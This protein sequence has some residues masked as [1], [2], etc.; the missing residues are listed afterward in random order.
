MLAQSSRRRANALL[1]ALCL[2]TVLPA[3][4]STVGPSG[5]E[6]C[7]DGA[8]CMDPVYWHEPRDTTPVS[9]VSLWGASA[10]NSCTDHAIGGSECAAAGGE[11]CCLAS[12]GC[13]GSGAV[14]EVEPGM[15]A[16]FGLDEDPECFTLPNGADY[17]GRLD[18][19][20]NGQPCLSWD[21]LGKIRYTEGPG[22]SD[23]AVGGL[24]GMEL[25][26]NEPMRPI[27]R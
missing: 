16:V 20:N 25:K 22:S 5:A 6:C 11:A 3:G 21:S 7:V 19:A 14:P 2:A 24:D 1:A 18:Y 12:C 15:P 8:L 10:A 9:D 23:V 27:L 13:E 17:R 26:M 4:G